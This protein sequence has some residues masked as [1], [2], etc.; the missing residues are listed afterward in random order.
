MPPSDPVAPC[1]A[2][3]V[4]DAALLAVIVPPRRSIRAHHGWCSHAMWRGEV[5]AGV[6]E[7]EGEGEDEGTGKRAHRGGRSRD[8]NNGTG[9]HGPELLREKKDQFDLVI[10][11][12]H[13]PDMDGFKLL[14]LV[15]LEMD[16][17]GIS[18]AAE[19]ELLHTLT[20]LILMEM[21]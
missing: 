15:G 8:D 19:E 1:V 2:A 17:P 12:V 5:T 9:S 14:E 7:V 18:E 13:M 6:A 4:M 20:M 21:K 11:N 3:P 10:S 16:L